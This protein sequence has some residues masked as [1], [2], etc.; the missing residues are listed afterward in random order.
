[1]NASPFYKNQQAKRFGIHG[2]KIIRTSKESAA[3]ERFETQKQQVS[4][5]EVLQNQ[6]MNQR[7]QFQLKQSHAIT[8][9]YHANVAADK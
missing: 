3:E 5:S 6:F 9:Q 2:A 7:D 4:T 8:A 1:M